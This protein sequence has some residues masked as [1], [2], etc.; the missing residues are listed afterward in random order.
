MGPN[1]SACSA[2]VRHRCD[3]RVR[4]AGHPAGDAH[5]EVDMDLAA[6]GDAVLPDH[7][8]ERATIDA[9]LGGVA[10]RVREFT[11]LRPALE[12]WGQ[13]ITAEV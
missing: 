13:E 1:A 10:G 12:P 4:R 9:I 8:A 3:Q 11:P 5:D 7:A 2:S 6:G